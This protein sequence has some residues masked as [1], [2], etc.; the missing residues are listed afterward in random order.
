[1]LPR[2]TLQLVALCERAAAG[3]AIAR[4]LALE[5][6][7]ALAVLASFDKGPDLV[8]YY[9]HLMM[10]AGHAGYDRHFN[11]ADALSES[12]RRHAEAQLALFRAWHAGW[13]KDPDA[14]RLCA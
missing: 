4:R 2:E 5:L 9:K 11:A 3:D 1:M 8:L 12:Q 7:E 14:A 13:M 6:D 10:V